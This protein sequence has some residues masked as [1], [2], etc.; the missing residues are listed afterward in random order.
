MKK[1]NKKK[2]DCENRFITM[3]RLQVSYVVATTNWL[4]IVQNLTYYIHVY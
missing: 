3:I 1:V 4:N 2:T